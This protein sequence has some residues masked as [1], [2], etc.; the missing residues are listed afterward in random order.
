MWQAKVQLIQDTVDQCQHLTNRMVRYT[1]HI[2]QS[3]ADAVVQNK[4]LEGFEKNLTAL[5]ETMLPIHKQTQNLTT[6]LRS[7]LAQ[8]DLSTCT[9]PWQATDL[10][11]TL[12][13]H[14][15]PLITSWSTPE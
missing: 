4:I 13:A 15:C 11:Q 12:T 5:N 14:W 2:D 6:A 10:A 8:H 3:L 7:E 1:S 9:C